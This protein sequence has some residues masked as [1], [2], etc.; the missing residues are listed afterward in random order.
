[1]VPL[2]TP[3]QAVAVEEVVAV[4]VAPAVTVAGTRILQLLASLIVMKCKP[5]VTPLKVKG[6]AP[7][8][9]GAPSSDQVKGA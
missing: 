5:A 2:F 7:G 1:M 8:T 6:L 3:V 9:A 4:G